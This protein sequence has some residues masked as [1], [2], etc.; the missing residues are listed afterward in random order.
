MSRVYV[1]ASRIIK[2]V[3]THKKGLGGSGVKNGAVFA[4]CCET[5]KYLQVLEEILDKAGV[6][7]VKR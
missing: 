1:E 5:L 3:R 2:D 4:L 7:K 6:F